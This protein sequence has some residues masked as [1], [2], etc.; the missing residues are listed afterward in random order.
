MIAGFDE[1]N[2][3]AMGSTFVSGVSGDVFS[4]NAMGDVLGGLLGEL[5]PF[6]KF[7]GVHCMQENTS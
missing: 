1:L 4:S 2:C 7:S 6:A 5:D 3:V